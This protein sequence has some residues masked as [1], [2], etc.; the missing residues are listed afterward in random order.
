MYPPEYR[1]QPKEKWT[2]LKESISQCSSCNKSNQPTQSISL[3]LDLI[4]A[5]KQR[6]GVIISMENKGRKKIKS[7]ES[8]L[9]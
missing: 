3:T 6:V 9:S 5:I 2:S 7:Y 4:E 8:D 1:D